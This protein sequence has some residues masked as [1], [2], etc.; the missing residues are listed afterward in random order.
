[1]KG[2]GIKNKI[3]KNILKSLDNGIEITQQ[4]DGIFLSK[5]L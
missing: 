4:G 1:M 2:N 5:L 3:F